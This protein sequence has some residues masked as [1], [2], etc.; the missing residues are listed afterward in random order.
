[1]ERVR[2][3]PELAPRDTAHARRIDEVEGAVALIPAGDREARAGLHSYRLDILVAGGIDPIATKTCEVDVPGIACE[4]F[5]GIAVPP[6][7]LIT[8]SRVP[9]GAIEIVVRRD[10]V[11]IANLPPDATQ[12]TEEPLSGTHE[13]EVIAMIDDPEAGGPRQMLL[14][15]C[16]VVYETPVVGG[17]QR[18]DCTGDGAQNISDAVC[19]LDLLFSGGESGCH[20]AADSDDGGGIDLTDAIF[21]LN[22]LFLGGPSLPAP[23][24]QCGHDATEDALT[25]LEHAPCFTPPPP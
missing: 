21:L 8:W 15:A 10:D 13:Y 6:Q 2:S 9:E 1:V 22:H 19:I 24:P 16:T 7:V 14:G 18:G 12:Y 23:F 5:G 17:F 25:C 11:V 4:V 3:G 20:E